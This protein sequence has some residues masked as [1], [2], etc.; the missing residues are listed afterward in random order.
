[1]SL[2]ARRIPGLSSSASPL[3]RL[4]VRGFGRAAPYRRLHL[5]LQ[6]GR[7][8]AFSEHTDVARLIALSRPLLRATTSA[9]S[10]FAATFT[11]PFAVRTSLFADQQK[12][13][14]IRDSPRETKSEGPSAAEDSAKSEESAGSEEQK[15]RQKEKE[16][17]PPP[18]PH[19]NKTP[20]QVFTDTLRSEFKASKEWNEGTKALGSAAH[21]FNESESVKRARAAYSAASDAAS[22]GTSSVLKNTGK[23]IGH[24]AAWTWDT[25]VVRGVR[26]GASAVGK[27]IDVATKPV[28]E[29]AAYKSIKDVIDDGSSSRYG[30]WVEKEERRKARELRE[31]NEAKTGKRRIERV[32]EDPK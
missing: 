18:P 15:S 3:T 20:W 8:S 22:S 29:T 16:T 27:G 5:L 4:P 26:K 32:V 9:R 19:G 21:Q 24:G 7:A 28:R 12:A 2:A 23:V 30:G 11:R 25:S 31:I 6:D 14:D 10:P 1:M 17:P 13:E